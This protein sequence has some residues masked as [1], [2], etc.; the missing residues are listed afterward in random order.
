MFHPV[1]RCGLAAQKP[2]PQSPKRARCPHSRLKKRLFNNQ[3]FNNGPLGQRSLPE[4]AA[5]YFHLLFLPVH[6]NASSA[7]SATAQSPINAYSENDALFGT[8]TSTRSD[9]RVK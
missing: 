3:A 5:F 9:P 8:A 1:G 6:P 7:P 4:E 2:S